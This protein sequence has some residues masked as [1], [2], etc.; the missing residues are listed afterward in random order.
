MA[1]KLRD[2]WIDEGKLKELQKQAG[3]DMRK[4]R[5]AVSL[6][7]SKR[8]SVPTLEVL[9][10]LSP[11]TV[12]ATIEQGK[13][14]YLQKIDGL[15]LPQSI[16]DNALTEFD[17]AKA[18]CV[19]AAKQ[20]EEILTQYEGVPCLFDRNG[21]FW[22]KEAPL[23][24]FLTKKA[25]YTYTPDEKAYYELLGNVVDDLNA[26]RSFER[27]KGWV[28]FSLRKPWQNAPYIQE[29]FLDQKGEKYEINKEIFNRLKNWQFL[30]TANE[31]PDLE[32][33]EAARRRK[34]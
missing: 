6:L 2:T 33:E 13:K 31:I 20:I 29:A 16:V 10:S 21:L 9:Q 32:R 23:A 26:L 15:Y 25:G 7:R 8:Y 34:H 28:E 17:K 3:E 12:S 14:D 5:S 4:V 19:E 1:H 22:W 30:A 11:A 24:E 27:Q 18:V